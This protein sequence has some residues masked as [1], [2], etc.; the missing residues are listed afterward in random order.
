MK[1]AI[2][3]Y[4][5]KQY[6]VKLSTRRYGLYHILTI[7]CT[8]ISI[9]Y[10]TYVTNYGHINHLTQSK[11]QKIIIGKN[12]VECRVKKLNVIFSFKIK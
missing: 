1:I 2:V 5:N 8:Y 12:S 6:I 7:L 10:T 11:Y 4:C 9:T 3:F